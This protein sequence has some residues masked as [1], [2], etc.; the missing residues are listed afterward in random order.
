MFANQTDASSSKA[1]RLWPLY[2]L[3]AV[4]VV[5]GVTLREPLTDLFT[6]DR[7]GAPTRPEF[8]LPSETN[9]AVR[10]EAQRRI[11]PTLQWADQESQRLIAIHLRAIEDYFKQAKQGTR[12]F[13]DD[14]LG[15]SSKWRLMVDYVPYTDGGRH[16]RY[17]RS[18][19]EHHVFKAEDLAK[20]IQASIAGYI[21]AL[22]DIENRMLVKMRADVADLPSTALPEFAD[23]K[24][25]QAAYV[26]AL[27]T[28]VDSSK[29]DLR[30]DVAREVAAM[31]AGEVL[32]FVAVKLGVSGGIL[33]AGA[34]SSWATFGVGLVVGLIV[35]QIVSWVWDWWADPKGELATKMNDQLDSI[36]HLMINGDAE[37]SGL[38]DRLTEIAAERK[39]IRAVALSSLLGTEE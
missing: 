23:N 24:V 35:D 36:L 37:N 15:Y 14:A 20:V 19:F 3:S 10:R 9:E 34:G 32:T 33:A 28:A 8:G 12:P 30:A 39:R 31:V 4:G 38:R 7:N 16:E 21:V 11:E 22:H 17:I 2:V 13:A 26:A 29:V 1:R 6:A 27:N 5:L 25:L 18:R